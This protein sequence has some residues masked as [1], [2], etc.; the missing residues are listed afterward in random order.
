MPLAD[1]GPDQTLALAATAQL[2]GLPNAMVSY[3]WSVLDKPS[4][5]TAVFSSATAQNPTY[6]P[7]DVAGNYLLLL[8]VNDGAASEANPL[9]A[10]DAARVVLRVLTSKLV[11]EKP[12]KGERNWHLAYRV[13]VDALETFR[14]LFNTHLVESHTGMHATS[15]A[16][17]L[18]KLTNNEDA[19][20]LHTHPGAGVAAAS[21]TAN[22]VVRLKDAPLDAGIPIVNTRTRTS[23]T[24]NHAGT[25]TTRTQV[26]GESEAHAAFRIGRGDLYFERFEATLGDGGGATQATRVGIYEMTRTQYQAND[27]AG[28]T[29][30]ADLILTQGAVASKPLDGSALVA[31]G[32]QVVLTSGNLLVVRVVSVGALA[33]KDLTVHLDVYQ[34]D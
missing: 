10:P 15:T 1:A 12:A 24:S 32:I 30:R 16:A 31:G 5:T 27:W 6:G 20:G 21:A 3:S 8:V 23:F 25:V 33:P 7:L 9:K 26:A 17:N 22:G 28:A 34:Q 2:A 29:L 19:T 11:V 18:K 14:N 4:A 13:L